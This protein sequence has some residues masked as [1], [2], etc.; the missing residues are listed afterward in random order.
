MN[1]SDA[2]ENTNCVLDVN[3]PAKRKA[4][5]DAE[6]EAIGFVGSSMSKKNRP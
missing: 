1:G 3:T 4:G 5:A 2:E 6:L